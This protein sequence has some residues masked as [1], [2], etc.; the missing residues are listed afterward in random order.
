MKSRATNRDHK[1]SLEQEAQTDEICSLFY[2]IDVVK[3]IYEGTINQNDP[4]MRAL[5]AIDPQRTKVARD[6]VFDELVFK[7]VQFATREPLI[8]DIEDDPTLL[9]LTEVM[10]WLLS[11]AIDLFVRVMGKPKFATFLREVAQCL[12]AE[13]FDRD[14]IRSVMSKYIDH[15]AFTRE[16]GED[17]EVIEPRL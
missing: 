14:T 3:G 8:G 4:P 17:L 16:R 1:R 13:Q 2:L 11:E 6:R 15:S 9:H 10:E 5:L 7:A 12:D